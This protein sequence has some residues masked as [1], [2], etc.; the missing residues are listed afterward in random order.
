MGIW[1]ESCWNF[2][3]YA[4]KIYEMMPESFQRKY[5][6]KC[7]VF[8]I[9]V[10]FEFKLQCLNFMT[11]FQKLSRDLSKSEK[12][13]IKLFWKKNDNLWKLKYEKPQKLVKKT[14]DRLLTV[15]YA[16]KRFSTIQICFKTINR[17][18]C[19]SSFLIYSL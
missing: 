4:R 9:W 16:F 8:K 14:K 1:G 6:G 12:R 18:N 13:T 17:Q 11:F 5:A 10:G 7:E 2:A 3:A 19:W 15:A